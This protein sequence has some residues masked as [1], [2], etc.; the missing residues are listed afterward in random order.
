MSV[1]KL[2]I[3]YEAHILFHG[4]KYTGNASNI[5]IFFINTKKNN[6]TL[7]FGRAENEAFKIAAKNFMEF[8]IENENLIE[9]LKQAITNYSLFK[10]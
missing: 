7:G 10:F 6:K 9:G 2:I 4:K 1:L 5:I 8:L 3:S